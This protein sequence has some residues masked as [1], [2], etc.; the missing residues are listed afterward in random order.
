MSPAPARR[1]PPRRP[2]A[3]SKSGTRTVSIG[4]LNRIAGALGVEA[5]DLVDH[6]D[7]A[8][9]PVVAILGANGAVAPKRTAIVVPPKVMPGL[10]AI[11]VAASL[12][13]YRAGDEIWCE[14]LE[15]DQFGRALNRDLLV[16]RPAGRFLFGRLIGREAD[17]LHLLPPARAGA[18]RS[19]AIRRGRRWR[20]G[21]CGRSSR[22]PL[23]FP[24]PNGIARHREMRGR[25]AQLVERF[26]YTEDVGGSSPSAPTIAITSTES[27]AQRMR[28]IGIAPSSR[29]AERVEMKAAS[30]CSSPASTTSQRCAT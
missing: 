9:L 24:A 3:G 4:W 5:S 17:K 23:P 28:A 15:P 30:G 2:S 13:D 21:S 19:S 18:R 6:P 16:P 11:T 26:L 20:S 7:R 22:G 1:R 29:A 14:R 27:N 10:I 12:G 25:L 8:E